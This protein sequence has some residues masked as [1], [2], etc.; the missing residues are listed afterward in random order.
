MVV[1]KPYWN[2]RDAEADD[3][4]QIVDWFPDRQSV[5]TWGGSEAAYPLTADWLACEFRAPRH[6]YR[7]LC[8]PVY[9]V[10]GI[11]G[12]LSVPDERRAHLR[13]IAIAPIYRGKGLSRLVVDDAVAIARA[14]GAERLTLNVY[15]SNTIAARAYAQAGFSI[16]E[17][18]PAPEDSSGERWAMAL[19]L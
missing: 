12:L 7:V 19:R 3:A 10:S 4:S 14:S 16:T 5:I 13:R 1:I 6:R 18:G 11:F 15:G 9:K 17:K 8:D 2:F